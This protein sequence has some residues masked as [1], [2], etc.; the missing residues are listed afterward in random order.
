MKDYKGADH[1]TA[2]ITGPGGKVCTKTDLVSD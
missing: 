2:R 1:V